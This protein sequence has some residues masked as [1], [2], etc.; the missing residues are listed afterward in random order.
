[1]WLS[2]HV[3]VPNRWLLSGSSQIEYSETP[4]SFNALASSGNI[5]SWRFAVFRG[6]ARKQSHAEIDLLGQA[7]AR[8]FGIA[9]VLEVLLVGGG[10]RGSAHIKTNIVE[11]PRQG[12]EQPVAAR[13]VQR[14]MEI[15]IK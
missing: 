3:R 2:A 11:A 10:R 5:S 9:H 14:S 6:L 7:T 4:A 13:F 12:R 15:N 8:A 1:V